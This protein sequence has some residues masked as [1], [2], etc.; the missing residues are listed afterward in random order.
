MGAPGRPTVNQINEQGAGGSAPRPLARVVFVTGKL[1][2]PA[3]RRVLEEM[4]PPFEARVAVLKITVAALMT[5]S[6]IARFLEIPP[7]TDLVLLPGLCE[8]D[9][10]AISERVGVPVEKGPKDLR[11]IPRYFGQAAAAL[12]YG[13]FAIEILAEINNAPRLSREAVRA[14]ADYYRASGADVIDI[15]CTPGLPFPALGDVVGELRAAG[16]RVSVDSFDPE[17]IRT[18]VGAGAELVLSV[19]GSNLDVARELGSS[20][21]RVVVIPDFGEGLDTLDRNVEALERWSVPYLIDPVIEPIGFGFMA[22]LERYAE[23]HRRYPEATLLM[24]VGNI[25]ELTSADSTGVN[26]LLI[27]ICEEIGVGAVLTTEVIPWA[28]GSVREIDIARRLM[29]YAV[30]HRTLPKGVD[31]RLLTVKDPL[32]L[33][34]SEEELRR[35]HAA[36]KDPN[37]RIFADRTTI[38]VFNHELFVRGTDIQEIFSR[39]GVEEGTHAFYLGRELMKAKLAITLGKTYRQEGALAWGYLTPPDDVKSGPVKLTQR[40]RRPER[41]TEGG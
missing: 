16:H 37:F 21:A 4:E 27:A 36:V 15:G 8:G 33:E 18:A 3:L 2:E 30:A 26:A 6:W 17:E 28:R 19:N 31:D 20:G 24:G 34:Y 35:L 14:A 38:T 40:K 12:D 23:V 25:T 5:T 29:H 9:T 10:A 7:D 32:V 11:E 1:A 39:L 22:S 41:R 13:R